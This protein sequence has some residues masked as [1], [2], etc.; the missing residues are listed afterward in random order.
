MFITKRGTLH[1][2]HC[3]SL[4]GSRPRGG[5]RGGGPGVSPVLEKVIMFAVIIILLQTRYRKILLF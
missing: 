2:V 1:S 3:T 4:V 5:W